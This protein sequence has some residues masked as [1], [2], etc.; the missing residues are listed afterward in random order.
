MGVVLHVRVFIFD[1]IESGIGMLLKVVKMFFE[2]LEEAFLC[3]RF[4]KDVAHT[5]NGSVIVGQ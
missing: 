5:C 1:V 2:E 4:G 3:E